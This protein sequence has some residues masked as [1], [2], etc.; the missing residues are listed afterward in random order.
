[1]VSCKLTCLLIV[2]IIFDNLYVIKW[3]EQAMCLM[4][5]NPLV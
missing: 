2:N 5:G 1:M 3:G 4:M